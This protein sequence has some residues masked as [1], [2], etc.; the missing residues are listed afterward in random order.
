MVPILS[1][2][3]A[4]DTSAYDKMAAVYADEAAFACQEWAKNA[5]SAINRDYPT[6]QIHIARTLHR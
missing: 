2:L 5:A 6:A 3:N 4:A 1:E